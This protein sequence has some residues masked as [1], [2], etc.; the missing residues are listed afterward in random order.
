MA[1]ENIQKEKQEEKE[2][3]KDT[4]Y[5]KYNI[6]INDPFKKGYTHQVINDLLQT[7]F[8][9]IVYYCLAE[10]NGTRHH[11]HIYTVFKTP[12][13]FS[14][15]KK[16]FK[17]RAYWKCQAVQVSKTANIYE[18]SGKWLESRK[19]ETVI[20]DTFEE[21]RRNASRTSRN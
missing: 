14:Q 20:P 8:K 15:I 2:M 12:V 3:I 5:R 9:S 11:I 19:H 4:M 13:R 7:K 17:E 6:T 10:E 16:V 21:W 18:K 1:K